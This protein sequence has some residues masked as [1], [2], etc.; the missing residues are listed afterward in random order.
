MNLV[1][2]RDLEPLRAVRLRGLFLEERLR[3]DNFE[4]DVCRLLTLRVRA[5]RLFFPV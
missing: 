1:Y 3:V 2:Y 4:A 5:E